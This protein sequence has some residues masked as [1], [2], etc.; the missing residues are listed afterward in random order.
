MENTKICKAVTS[1]VNG[2][3]GKVTDVTK[4]VSVVEGVYVK[5]SGLILV[6]AIIVD[7]KLSFADVLTEGPLLAVPDV[8]PAL[9][10]VVLTKVPSGDGAVSYH[11]SEV[12]KYSKVTVSYG[13]VK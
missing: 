6:F 9:G 3:D 1:V 12:H 5:P 2:A 11:A 4:V 7:G 8:A 13:E 10:G